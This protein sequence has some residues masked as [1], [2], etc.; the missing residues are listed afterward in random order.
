NPSGNTLNWTPVLLND[1]TG[2]RDE[3]HGLAVLA[4][5]DGSVN[6]YVVGSLATND[7]VAQSNAFIAVL[8]GAD[9]SL[10]NSVVLPNADAAGVAVDPNSGDILVSGTATDPSSGAKNILAWAE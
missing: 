9:G 4:N 10:L 7:P 3:A 2:L 6:V 1:A 5:A 8:S